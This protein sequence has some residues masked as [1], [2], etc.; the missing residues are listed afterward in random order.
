MQLSRQQRQG[1]LLVKELAID[2]SEKR[3]KD[4]RGLEYSIGTCLMK[5]SILFDID[6]IAKTT[7]IISR[8]I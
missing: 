7:D 1:E 5:K 6:K 2:A 8:R 3:I 4:L